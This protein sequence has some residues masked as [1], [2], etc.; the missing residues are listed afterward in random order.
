[1][2]IPEFLFPLINPMMKLLLNS[3]LHP[4]MSHSVLVLYFKGRKSG[5]KYS[6]PLR[7]HRDDDVV[8]C[9]TS[10]ETNWWRNFHDSSPASIQI[11]GERQNIVGKLVD[12]GTEVKRDILLNYLLAFP[13]DAVYHNVRRQKGILVEEDLDAAAAHCRIVE[14]SKNVSSL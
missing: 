2:K 9:F 11:R 13:A 4:L 7:Y 12:A 3:P 5:R 6:T 8:R 14:F 10:G 1:M